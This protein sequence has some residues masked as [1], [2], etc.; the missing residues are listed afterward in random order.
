MSKLEI[1][2]SGYSLCIPSRVLEFLK[3]DDTQH[4]KKIKKSK[5]AAFT[6]IGEATF[7]SLVKGLDGILSINETSEHWNWSRP[8][9]NRFFAGLSA[10]NAVS[11]YSG[12]TKFFRLSPEI[13][14]LSK[15]FALGGQSTVGVVK[16]VTAPSKILFSAKTAE[17]ISE[18]TSGDVSDKSG[19]KDFGD[20]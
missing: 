9:V 18:T 14:I 20:D 3:E 1:T 11:M 12:K 15:D 8:T 2:H 17:Q 16:S 6:D 4:G 10:L 7:I 13:F 5:L 19:T